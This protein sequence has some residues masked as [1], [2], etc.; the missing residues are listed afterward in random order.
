MPRLPSPKTLAVDILHL[1]VLLSIH[2]LRVAILP[3][4]AHLLSILATIL[5]TPRH[6]T[7]LVAAMHLPPDPLRHPKG[8]VFRLPPLDLARPDTTLLPDL[9]LLDIR[10]LHLSPL[11]EAIQANS[12]TNN[13][14]TTK[15]G[16][17]ANNISPLHRP[18]SRITRRVGAPQET[19]TILLALLPAHLLQSRIM[20]LISKVRTIATHSPTSSIPNVLGRRRLFAL[21]STT[22]ARM[23][24]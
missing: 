14:V 16:I 11:P 7:P 19:N 6:T 21:V 3:L 4:P 22:L 20:D 15:A 1:L 13:T 18:P 2:S 24:N 8:L 9:L 5:V 23:A 10:N 12:G 17:L